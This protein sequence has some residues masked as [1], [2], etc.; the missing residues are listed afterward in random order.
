MQTLLAKQNTLLAEQLTLGA[1]EQRVAL[2]V[3]YFIYGKKNNLIFLI[4]FSSLFP[5]CL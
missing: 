1:L 5:N 3:K 4:S 2:M